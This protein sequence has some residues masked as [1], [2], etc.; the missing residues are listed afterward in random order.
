MDIASFIVI[1]AVVS[2]IVQFL[3]NRFGTESAITLTIVMALSVVSGAIYY[4]LKE[5]TLWQPIL[6]ILAFAGAIY[7]YI[8]KRFE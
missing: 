8:L 4:F 1:G 7:T 2:V 6:Q 5:T 3:K